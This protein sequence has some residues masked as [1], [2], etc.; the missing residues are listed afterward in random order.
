[1]ETI[2]LQYPHNLQRENLPETVLAV[3]YF[4]GVH[5]GHQKVIQ[6]AI[7][8]ARLEGKESAVMTFDPHPSIVLKR[9][10]QHV[11]LITPLNEKVRLLKELGVDRV[12]VV[13]F[14][15]DLAALLPQEFVDH[16]FIG[17]HVTHVVAGFDFSYGRMGKGNMETLPF[18]SR[19]QLQQTTVQKVMSDEEKISSSLIRYHLK[20]GDI[21]YVKD[22]LGRPYTNRGVV[23]K[24]DQRGRTIG[25]P[26]ANIDVHKD[27]LIPKVGVYAV[28]IH[29]G[30]KIYNGMANVGYKPTFY[31]D[32][33]K[34][35]V[36]VYIFDFQGDLY[37]EELSVE[38]HAFIRN[39]TK[40]NGVEQLVQQL[41]AD[42]REIRNFFE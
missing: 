22:L 38:W 25:F 23:V 13:T 16:F 12:Y 41:K 37:G 18:H 29:I 20:E 4:D 30:D 11:Q 24:G 40:F 1:M 34:L 27:Y 28:R 42:E 5:K 19:E 8:Q 35:S 14:N 33:K 9:K 6:T 7:E 36:E 32:E 31:E 21:S 15:E 26:T 3:G 2:T 39:E 10:E 17:L